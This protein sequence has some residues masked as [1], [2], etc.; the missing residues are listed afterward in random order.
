MKKKLLF[1]LLLLASAAWTVLIFTRSMKVASESNAESGRFL[2]VLQKILPFLTMN[3]LRKLAHFAEFAVLG[4][5][6]T[7]TVHSFWGKRSYLLVLL[8][9]LLTALADETIQLFVAG[10]SSQL[11]DIWLDFSGSLTAFLLIIG[12]VQLKKRR[13]RAK[14]TQ[15]QKSAAE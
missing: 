6:L 5:L 11:T 12:I 9:A 13:R 1:W 7:A 2:V 3:L 8:A 14:Q 10:R 15:A 4:G